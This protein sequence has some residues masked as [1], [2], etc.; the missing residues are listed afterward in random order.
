MASRVI[1]TLFVL[2]YAACS[3]GLGPFPPSRSRRLSINSGREPSPS[4]AHEDGSIFPSGKRPAG[5][6]N[7]A[8]NE[9]LM[10]YFLR[11]LIHERS[12]AVVQQAVPFIPNRSLPFIL[13]VHPSLEKAH[14]QAVRRHQADAGKP[15]L[16][17]GGG[18]KSRAPLPKP[19]RQHGGQTAPARTRTHAQ[20]PRTAR[21][22]LRNRRDAGL[23][24]A[25]PRA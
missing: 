16:G 5:K 13:H 24:P 12:P 25:S 23:R 17:E 1:M 7:T 3:G 4:V 20:S 14:P 18:E 21:G 8:D 2:L 11:Y 10:H 19:H 9:R 15:G 22:T 6:F